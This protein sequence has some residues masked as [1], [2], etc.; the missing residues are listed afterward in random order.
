MGRTTKKELNENSTATT[1]QWEKHITGKEMSKKDHIQK[2]TLLDRVKNKTHAV[3]GKA[4]TD[5]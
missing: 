1:S 4:K 5:A 2:E 3:L